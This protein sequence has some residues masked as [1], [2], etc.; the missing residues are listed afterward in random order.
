LVC[1]MF[2]VSFRLDAARFEVC[3]ESPARDIPSM[4][5]ALCASA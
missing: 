4:G 3:V 2:Q 5:D 1:D